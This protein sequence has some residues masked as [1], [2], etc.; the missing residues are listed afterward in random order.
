MS[1][2]QGARYLLRLYVTGKTPNSVRAIAN[3]KELCEKHL[4]DGYDLQVIDIYQQPELAED[5]QIVA[6]P[7][8]VKELPPPLR[9]L[10]GDLSDRE[11]VLIKLDLQPVR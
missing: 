7:T 4:P 8:L 10:I 3:L 9:K 5:D 11:R 1:S 6:T 2:P